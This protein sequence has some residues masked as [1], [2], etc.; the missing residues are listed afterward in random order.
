MVELSGAA[1][2]VTVEQFKGNTMISFREFYQ[3]DGQWLHGKKGI[4][5]T[6]PQWQTLYANLDGLK[7]SFAELSG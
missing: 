3:K 6:V 4:N 7:Q 1:R 5:L 2:R